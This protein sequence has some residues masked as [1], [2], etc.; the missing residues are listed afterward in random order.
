LWVPVSVRDPDRLAVTVGSWRIGFDN[1][2]LKVTSKA[3]DA[4][5]PSLPVVKSWRGKTWSLTSAEVAPDSKLMWFGFQVHQNPIPLAA[6]AVGLGIVGGVVGAVFL[7]RE[8]RRWLPLGDLSRSALPYVA[9]G[10]LVLW[11]TVLLTRAKAGK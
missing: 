7:V 11:L 5:M 8:L 3:L 1:S 9:A 10:V 2:L 4:L 6:I